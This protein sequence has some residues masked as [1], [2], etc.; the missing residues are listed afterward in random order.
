MPQQQ[1]QYAPQQPM[2]PPPIP[3]GNPYGSQY[4]QGL[5]PP[6]KQPAFILFLV[7][8]ILFLGGM[9]Q[10]PPPQQYHQQPPPQ[11]YA[12][13][14]P[15]QYAQQSQVQ[16]KTLFFFFF[17]LFVF[18]FFWQVHHH[19]HQQQRSV[20]A[21]VPPPVVVRT[22]TMYT[23]QISCSNL[24]RKDVF[25]KS[26][27]FCI[28]SAKRNPN[29]VSYSHKTQSSRANTMVTGDWV[30]VHKTETIMNNHKPVIYLF[31][32]SFLFFFFSFFE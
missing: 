13:A 22:P 31:S 19:H 5:A 2:A 23:M 1:Q 25:S 16:V 20:V 15:P 3:G 9:P 26:D 4:G 29:N 6:G 12:Q 28:L 8:F 11:Q 32:F 10:G 21:A 7:V 30:V 14:P 24:D 17:F 18:G 27:P